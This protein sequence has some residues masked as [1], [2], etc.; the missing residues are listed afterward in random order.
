MQFQELHLREEILRA[1]Q[2]RG[3]DEPPIR[4]KAIPAVL[5]GRDVIGSA[6]TGTGKTA[7]FL[8]PSLHRLKGNPPLL[9]LTP[10]RELA[11]RSRKRLLR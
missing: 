8:L 9:V 7:A 10:T 11:C 2:E 5:E 6:Q 4:A 1:I 3:Y